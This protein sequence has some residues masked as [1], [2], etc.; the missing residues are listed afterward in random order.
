M[1]QTTAVCPQCK[2]EVA[3]EQVGPNR[4]C[5]SCGYSHP[6]EAAVPP[7]LPETRSALKIFGK[8]V[9][10]T[11]AVVLVLLAIAFAGCLLM[12]GTR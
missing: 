11:A 12:F 2:Q 5:P 4:Q 7:P 6:M 10:V 9:L 3:F 8:I 1:E